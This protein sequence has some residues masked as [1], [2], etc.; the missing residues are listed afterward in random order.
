[1]DCSDKRG[2]A[3]KNEET[4]EWTQKVIDHIKSFPTEESHYGRAKIKD[5]LYLSPDLN[6]SRMYRAFLEKHST[7]YNGK[8]PISRQWYHEIFL[9]KF[10]LSFSMPR[11]DTCSTCDAL[12]IRL[13]S[14]DASAKVDQELHHRRAEATTEA[15]SDDNKNAKTSDAY[16]VS[17]DLQQQM[18]LPQLTHTE[19]YYSQQ[20]ACCNLGIH[21]STKDQGC[22]FLWSENY[23][24]RGSTEITSCIYQ[25]LTT[26]CN[27]GNKKKLI[28]W[29][30][31]CGGQNKNQYMMAMYLVLIAN[32]VFDEVIHKFPVKGHTFL[33]CDRDFALIEKRKR[34]CKAMTIK[35]LIEI[36]TGAAQK[37]PFTCT[38]VE[39]FHNF[40]DIAHAFLHTKK[41]GIS[42][43]SQLRL[44]STEFGSVM[45]A[46]GG[47][48]AAAWCD[49]IKIVK[50][51]VGI[52]D[53]KNL[54]LHL[55]RTK[56][57]VPQKKRAD[58]TKMLPYLMPE[59]WA[60]FEELLAESAPESNGTTN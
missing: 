31:N 14:G 17:F 19:M 2:G 4:L 28:M 42:Q 8:P 39:E 43:A 13:K 7:E 52:D 57:G 59:A 25:Y 46:K 47:S 38:L 60:Y 6:V 55:S 24:G 22:M 56:T 27:P 41:L 16:V 48:A 36:I 1:M 37:K 32:G 40:K 11:V 3:R 44:T 23:G 20:L 9:T 15:M 26:Q 12:N 45:V 51:G 49:P 33:S 54:E 34:K 50:D 29:S 21:D 30:D 5:R 58:I 18:Y 53:L 10:N 35:D